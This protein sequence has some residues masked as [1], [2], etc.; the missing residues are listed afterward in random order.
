MA[1]SMLSGKRIGAIIA[2]ERQI[3]LRNYIEGGI[4]LDAVMTYD[5]LLSIF[6]PL[7]PL[8]DGAEPLADPSALMSS[9]VCA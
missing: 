6:Q 7:S 8:H 3:G 4:P 1:T 5:L 9:V 2:I